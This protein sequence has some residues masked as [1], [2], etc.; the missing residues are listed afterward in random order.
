[1]D[2]FFIKSIQNEI[3]F[4]FLLLIMGIQIRVTRKFSE[5]RRTFFCRRI[6][7][8]ADGQTNYNI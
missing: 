3:L 1:M 4:N 5:K 7:N 8:L 6:K 2:I